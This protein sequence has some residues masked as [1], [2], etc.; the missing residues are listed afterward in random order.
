MPEYRLESFLRRRYFADTID[1]AFSAVFAY[2]AAILC[3]MPSKA[4]SKLI[5]PS[6]KCCISRMVSRL[7]FNCS[8]RH[9]PII[10]CVV[11]GK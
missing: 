11:C 2:F 5:L 7:M 3:L 6:A 4:S 1:N 10:E 9:E 8:I